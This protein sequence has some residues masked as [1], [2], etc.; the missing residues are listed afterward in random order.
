M[1]EERVVPCGGA[2]SFQRGDT[3]IMKKWI[4]LMLV[5][6]MLL[7]I[8]PVTM[9]EPEI[10][11]D[12]IAIIVNCK[13][14]A[15]VRAKADSDS[16]KLGEAARGTSYK[17]LA[18]EGKWYKIQYTK[19][20]TGY[21]YYK[22][23]KVGK[24]GDEPSSS[25]VTVTNAP[26]GVNIRAKA[27]SKSKILGV[28]Y[29][30]ESFEKKGKSGK[31]T[32]VIYDGDTAYIF[33]SYLSGGSSSSSG[34][35]P[36]DNETGYIDCNTKVNVRAKD[37]SSSKKLGT[38]KRGAEITI[39]GTTK[40]WTRISYKDGEGFVY[41]KYVSST[42]PDEDISGKNAT[43]VN[44]NVCVNVRSKAS[45]SSK[46]LGTADKGATYTALGRKGNWIKVD[47]DGED[48]YI[49]KKYVKIG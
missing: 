16:K 14:S 49:Y 24:K 40:K 20:K 35:T 44:C 3:I 39:T 26:N 17:L 48:G 2:A 21:V 6:L 47:Y 23:V 18:K 36:V 10:G 12:S 22:Y 42:K 33:S 27:S 19:S 46:K 43:I 34:I 9:A 15:N 29:T 11:E 30:G 32:K 25:K 28:A 8:V 41:S 38:L 1:Q 7:A 4:S 37:S 13:N 31:W 5:A 45:S